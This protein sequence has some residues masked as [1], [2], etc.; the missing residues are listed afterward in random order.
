MKK[1]R[2]NDRVSVER[3]TLSLINEFD[4]GSSILGGLSRA[5]IE[6]WGRSARLSKV[7]SVLSL[8]FQISAKASL[9]VENSRDSFRGEESSAFEDCKE[10]IRQLQDRLAQ[11][12]RAK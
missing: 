9:I 1:R 10:L 8:L 6:H 7:D 4:E 2:F 12:K 11:E 3:A 5:A